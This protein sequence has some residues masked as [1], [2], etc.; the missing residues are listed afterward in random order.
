MA[1]RDTKTTGNLGESIA[2]VFLQKKGLRVLERNFRKP[3]GEIDIIAEKNGIIRFVEVKSISVPEEGDF[4]REMEYRPEELVTREKLS[5][6]ARTA[7]LYMDQFP[8]RE[9]QID[10]VGVLIK[11]RSRKAH[12]RFF[13]QVL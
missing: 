13:E 4:S 11:H 2:C 7:S 3:W 1:Q 10:V 5:K 6:I 12:C 8:D 9:Y